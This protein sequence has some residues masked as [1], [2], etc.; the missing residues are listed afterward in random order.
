MEE[1][2]KSSKVRVHYK[3]FTKGKDLKRAK[4]EDLDSLFGRRKN[5][6]KVDSRIG[7]REV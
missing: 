7:S 5:Y 3:K 6:E 1:R 2:S 4:E